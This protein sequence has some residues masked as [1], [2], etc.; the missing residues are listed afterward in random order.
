MIIRKEMNKE[1]RA[2]GM[3]DAKAAECVKQLSKNEECAIK[4]VAEQA[5]ENL[6]TI[7][8]GSAIITAT[9]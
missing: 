1:V 5:F 3:E 4:V 7:S 6:M 9:I 8:E 2:N